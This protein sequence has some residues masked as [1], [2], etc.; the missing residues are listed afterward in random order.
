MNYLSL[1]HA[2]GQQFDFVF[3]ADDV[4]STRRAAIELVDR[5]LWNSWSSRSAAVKRIEQKLSR[6]RSF[7]QDEVRVDLPV[8]GW[9]LRVADAPQIVARQEYLRLRGEELAEQGRA[10]ARR[11][12]ELDRQHGVR[13]QAPMSTLSRGRLT[14]V[15][16]RD[17]NGV[18]RHTLS[19]VATRAEAAAVVARA[20]NGSPARSDE[21][22]RAGGVDYVTT[23]G[24]RG[25]IPYTP[26]KRAR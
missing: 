11:R 21:F 12:E 20:A 10:I 23:S 1:H 13:P 4:A 16:N 22:A 18:M 15:G 25:T 5:H 9:E 2:D 6:F 14:M 24:E 8:S 7:V 19:G 17:R 3:A 26:P